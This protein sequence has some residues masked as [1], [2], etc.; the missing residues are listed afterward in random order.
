MKIVLNQVTF[1]I[2]ALIKKNPKACPC[3]F[4]LDSSLAVNRPLFEPTTR[5]ILSCTERDDAS[6]K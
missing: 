6:L 3:S 5:T 2:N 1:V 4:S